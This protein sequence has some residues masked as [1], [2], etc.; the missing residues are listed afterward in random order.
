M[1][2]SFTR[3]LLLAFAV[4]LLSFSG[5]VFAQNS[6]SN[7]STLLKKGAPEATVNSNF[8]IELPADQP[9]VDFYQLDMSSYRFDS[10][11]S[12]TKFCNSFRDNLIEITPNLTT[13]TAR[14]HIHNEYLPA[15]D[16]TIGFWNDYLQQKSNRKAQLISETFPINPT[17]QE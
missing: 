5:T 12:A 8:R 3:V 11:K 6:A 13:Q 10:E 2:Q 16:R 15:A 9:L 17:S 7:G 1:N 14:L 4:S